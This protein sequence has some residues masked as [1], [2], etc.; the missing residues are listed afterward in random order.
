MGKSAAATAFERNYAI[1]H[2]FFFKLF[3][4]LFG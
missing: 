2:S 4:E 1:L 3:D